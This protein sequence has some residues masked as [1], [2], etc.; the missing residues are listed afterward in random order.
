MPKITHTILKS[1]DLDLGVKKLGLFFEKENQGLIERLNYG[2]SRKVI[3]A[4]SSALQ[5]T[6]SMATKLS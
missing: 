2:Y 4:V 6:I 3:E 5:K 1:K